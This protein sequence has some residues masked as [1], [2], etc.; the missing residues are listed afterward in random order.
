M[1]ELRFVPEEILPI[2]H[3]D[4]DDWFAQLYRA[5]YDDTPVESADDDDVKRVDTL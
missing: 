2:I 4:V 5:I 1:S 3:A